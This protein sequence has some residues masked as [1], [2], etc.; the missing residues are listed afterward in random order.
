MGGSYGDGVSRGGFGFEDGAQ[1][2]EMFQQF[3][4]QRNP[5]DTTAE[6]YDPME[7]AGVIKSRYPFIPD[8]TFQNWLTANGKNSGGMGGYQ[9]AG[10]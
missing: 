6:G 8:Q 7:H 10:R 4:A 2:A 3:Q 9:F 5:T 1:I